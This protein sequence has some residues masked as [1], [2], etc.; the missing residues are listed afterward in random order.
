MDY[1]KKTASKI[2]QKWFPQELV[3]CCC[4]CLIVVVVVVAFYSF[5]SSISQ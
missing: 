1:F 2:M 4:C 3:S 5:V